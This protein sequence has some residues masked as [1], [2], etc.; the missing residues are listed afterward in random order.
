MEFWFETFFD[1]SSNVFFRIST[2][3]IEHV[4]TQCY[5][6]IASVANLRFVSV[7]NFEFMF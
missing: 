3:S 4:V 6:C 7:F 2:F 5:N 1:F